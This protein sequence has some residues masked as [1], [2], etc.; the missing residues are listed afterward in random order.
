VRGLFEKRISKAAADTAD[1]FDDTRLSLYVFER[2]EVYERVDSDMNT[3][4]RGRKGV[5][6]PKS[7]NVVTLQSVKKSAE[8][9]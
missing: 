7:N 5:P 1:F 4:K 2:Y 8:G 3:A 9:G 6:L